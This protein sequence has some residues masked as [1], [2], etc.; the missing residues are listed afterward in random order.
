MHPSSWLGVVLPGLWFVR[1]VGF[2]TAV[3]AVHLLLIGAGV[4][5]ILGLALRA[6]RRTSA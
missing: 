3:F 5:L 2:G 4:F 6:S 1:T